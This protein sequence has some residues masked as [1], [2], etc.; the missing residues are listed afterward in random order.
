MINITSQVQ[1]FK[2][3]HYQ[4]I[5]VSVSGGADSCALLH[6]LATSNLPL[7]LAVMHVNFGLRGAE[8]DADAEHVAQLA[9][10]F[11][12]PLHSYRIN[13]CDR[14]PAQQNLQ[15]WARNIR[16][17][18]LQ[19][20][21]RQH[22]YIVAIAHHHD[23]LAENILYRLVQ[24]KGAGQLSG[25]RIF[26]HPF[27][28]PLLSISRQEIV[29]YCHT[30]NI[31]YRH[32]SSN[33]DDKYARN[34][35]RQHVLTQLRK[36]NPQATEKITAVGDDLQELYEQTQA[37]LSQHYRH[38]LTAQRIAA[39]TIKSL[40][41][42]K[43]KLLL[44]LFLGKQHSTRKLILHVYRQIIDNH[45]FVICVNDRQLLKF[46]DRELFFSAQT[47]TLKINRQEQYQR[48]LHYEQFCAALEPNASAETEAGM[49]LT[50]NNRDSLI[51][52]LSRP[53]AKQKVYWQGKRLSFKELM[54]SKNIGFAGSLRWYLRSCQSEQQPE[55]IHI[56]GTNA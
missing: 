2:D 29:D 16:L 9:A 30:N 19:A 12:L 37:E 18:K 24:G 28:R 22:G 14:Q 35:I 50:A 20:F 21:A 23:D 42:S 11:A 46:S 52:C 36:I 38:E 4:G 49:V 10:E 47:A 32:D 53:S 26:Q 44:H 8:A 31:S 41:S 40:P 56:R 34:R 33:T 1:A 7:P 43:A 15:E 17:R 27:W 45:E 5:A 54:R 51:Y 25:M 13:S 6:L 48:A 55:V 3:K 39:D